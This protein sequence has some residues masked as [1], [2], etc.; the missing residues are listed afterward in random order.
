VLHDLSAYWE[1]VSKDKDEIESEDM[2]FNY[3]A[4]T[5]IVL[6]PFVL[7]LSEG[8]EV[9]IDDYMDVGEAM[10]QIK[11]AIMGT[12]GKRIVK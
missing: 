7:A 10:A 9:T 2:L 12:A 4:V 6:Q 1:H 3:V 11:D 8:K 5:Q